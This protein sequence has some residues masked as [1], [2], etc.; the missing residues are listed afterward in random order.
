MP[1]VVVQVAIFLVKNVR[2][3]Q[4]GTQVQSASVASLDILSRFQV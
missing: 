3:C 1:M 4:H 2:M